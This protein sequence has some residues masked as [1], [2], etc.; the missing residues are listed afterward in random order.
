MVLHFVLN[1][2]VVVLVYFRLHFTGY[3]DQIV[4]KN[5]QVIVKAEALFTNNLLNL[6][7]VNFFFYQDP[8]FFVGSFLD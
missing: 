4:P 1:V 5:F 6:A 8:N 3:P 2:A 7:D